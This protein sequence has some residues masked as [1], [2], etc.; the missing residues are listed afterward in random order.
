MLLSCSGYFRVPALPNTDIVA[1]KRDIPNGFLV[2]VLWGGPDQVRC[3][4][5]RLQVHC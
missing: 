5:P 2:N 4:D 3:G 1:I